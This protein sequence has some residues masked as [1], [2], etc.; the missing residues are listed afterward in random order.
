MAESHATNCDQR[1]IFND[2]IHKSI[3]LHPLLINIIDTHEFQRLRD[4]KQLGFCFKVF[5]GATSTRFDHSIGVCHLSWR[6]MEQLNCNLDAGGDHRIEI[7]ETEKLCVAVAGLCHDL[8]HGP[9]SHTWESFM[10]RVAPGSNWRHENSSVEVFNRIWEKLNLEIK[11]KYHMGEEERKLIC[12]I[13]LGQP[14]EDYPKLR[15]KEF[16]FEIVANK[17]SGVDVDKWDYFA[18]D[19]Y[20]L[21]MGHKISFE[22]ERLLKCARI[23]PNSGGSIHYRDSEK[24]NF[25]HMFYIRWILYHR[26]YKHRVVKI[27]EGMFIDALIAADCDILASGKKLSECASDLDSFMCLNDCIFNDLLKLSDSHPARQ[28][29]NRIQTRNL[30]KCVGQCVTRVVNLSAETIE[31]EIKTD[32]G[33]TKEQFYISVENFDYGMG[34]QDPVKC[35]PFYRKNNKDDNCVNC[36]STTTMTPS[37]FQESKIYCIC[38]DISEETI[39]KAKKA[40]SNWF[41]KSKEWLGLDTCEDAVVVE[42]LV[43]C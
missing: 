37:H 12:D 39:L 25:Y 30:Y 22:Y 2:P 33:L 5:P 26:A 24:M 28:L 14:S 6:L 8:G 40:F 35:I 17:K 9:F 32:T 18:R 42:D 19:N 27:I 23:D 31:S 11:T 41:N 29:I 21:A 1:K 7:S 20:Y 16:L 10:K 4:I 3:S 34:A 36:N 38:R 13:I 15:D 43:A